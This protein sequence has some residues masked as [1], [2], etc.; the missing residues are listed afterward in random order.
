LIDSFGGAVGINLAQ[1][2]GVGS[3]PNALP[4]FFFNVNGVGYASLTTLDRGTRTHQWN[5]V[6]TGSQKFGGHFL[7]FGFDYRRIDSPLFP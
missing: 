2:M 7:K 4:V 1:A 6:D 3:Y 5:V